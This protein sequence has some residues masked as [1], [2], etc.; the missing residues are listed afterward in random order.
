M[1]AFFFF[2][3]LSAVLAHSALVAIRRQNDKIQE[4]LLE[5]L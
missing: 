3:L 2:C 4:A 5:H 1:Q